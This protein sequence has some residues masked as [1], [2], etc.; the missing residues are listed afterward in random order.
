MIAV[1]NEYKFD[2]RVV[3]VAAPRSGS[4]L[5]FETLTSSKDFWTIGGESHGVFESIRQFNPQSGLCNS[6]ALTAQDASPE[7]VSQIRTS[8]FSQLRNSRGE[9]FADS[10]HSSTSRPRFLEK[11]P[12]NAVRVSLLNAVFPDALFI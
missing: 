7:I 2:R 4:T 8:F 12:K 1:K 9:P 6:N 11:T 5:L 10:N 3:I